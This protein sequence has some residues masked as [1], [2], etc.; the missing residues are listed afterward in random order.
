[1]REIKELN[2]ETANLKQ[3]LMTMK[4]GQVLYRSGEVVFAGVLNATDNQAEIDK[5]IQWLVS[6]ANM[7][8]LERLGMKPDASLEPTWI[9][10]DDIEKSTQYYSN[11]Q[12]EP[13]GTCK[14]SCQYSCRSAYCLWIEC[15]S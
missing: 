9:L 14:G 8:A 13:S 7:A 11:Q 3:G 12:D 10:K 6:N 4:E 5:E 2:T 1:M 15:L